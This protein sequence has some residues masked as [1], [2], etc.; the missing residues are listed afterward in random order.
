M[1]IQL[2]AREGGTFYYYCRE[3]K[4]NPVLDKEAKLDTVNLI[5]DHIDC[6]L[7]DVIVTQG[8]ETTQNY[9]QDATSPVSIIGTL[10][11]Q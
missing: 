8:T 11:G 7:G 2:S 5:E 10:D 3:L 1:P 4:I 9:A 6:H